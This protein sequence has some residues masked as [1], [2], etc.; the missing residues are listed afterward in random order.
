LD[1]KK[2]D[3]IEI[4]ILLPT[5]FEKFFR[6]KLRNTKKLK[7]EKKSGGVLPS[8]SAAIHR[9]VLFFKNRLREKSQSVRRMLKMNAP[10]YRVTP[11]KNTTHCHN[12]T[13]GTFRATI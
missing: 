7:K 5:I 4:E 13:T 3:T 9:H 2:G 1:A 8:K 12:K 10:R 6:K 11:L